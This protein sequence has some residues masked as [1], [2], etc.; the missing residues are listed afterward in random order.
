MTNSNIKK[1]STN[2]LKRKMFNEYIFNYGSKRWALNTTAV[3]TLVATQLK[4][5]SA[6]PYVSGRAKPGFDN[7]L[8]GR[9]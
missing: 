7:I 6:S 1:N 5:C 9:T 2:E 4:S 8:E 3:E